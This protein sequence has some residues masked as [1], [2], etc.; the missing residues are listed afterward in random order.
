MLLKVCIRNMSAI[1][2]GVPLLEIGH[3]FHERVDRR[4]GDGIVDACP[5]AAHGAMTFQPGQARGFRLLE[6]AAVPRDSS[7][8]M[9]GTFIHE[10]AE[11]STGFR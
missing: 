3:E 5:H 11:G 10:R 1:R 8:R 4:F 7:A 6:E 9:N 2:S